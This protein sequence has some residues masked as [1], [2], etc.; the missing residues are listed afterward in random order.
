MKLAFFLL[1]AL[2]TAFG[3]WLRYINLQHLKRYGN[4]VPEGFEGV[5]DAEKLRASSA[6]TLASSRLSLWESLCDNALLIVF[7]FG[8]LIALYDRFIGGLSG[9]F[10]LF[11]ILF[12]LILTWAQALLGIPFHLYATF[13][14]EARY[15]FNTMTPR[16]W[17]GDFLKSQVIGSLLLTL[18]VAAA[19]GLIRWSPERWWI[20]V[21]G[22]MGLFSL[23]MMFISPYVIEPL[24]NKFEPVTEEG[25][26]AEIRAMME[27]AGL[28]VGRVMQMD[29]SR[30]SRHSNAYFTG[31]GRVKRIVLFDTLIS[32]MTHAE[33]VAVLA[34]G[35]GH[36]K[37]GHI[38]KRLAAAE[39][40]AL[41]GAWI[42]FRLLGWE[43]LPGLLGL[44]ADLSLPG[45]MVVLGFVGSLAMFPLTPLS[46]WLSRRHE[47]EADRFAADLTGRPE[48]LASAMVKLSA[49]NLSNL[50]PHPWYAAFHYSH[51]P[52]VERVRTLR[53][54]ANP[55]RGPDNR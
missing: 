3:Y 21:W 38:W 31:I 17:A 41:A 55:D 25:L 27:K 42:S 4:E 7:L 35:I 49:E 10:V 13:R 32:R 28:K 14:I 20:W 48:A 37:L 34:H 26:E 12:F 24:F 40:L 22:F 2:V 1:F 19:F 23:L 53:G 8:G 9:S 18:L 39:L 54:W 46:A 16:L 6:Y 5:V 50:F 51:P 47:R 33:I 44:P 36:W 11:A 15:G 43:G 45:R 30:R 52:A 29:A